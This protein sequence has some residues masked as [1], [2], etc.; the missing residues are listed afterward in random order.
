MRKRFVVAAV[1]IICIAGLVYASRVRTRQRFVPSR[2]QIQQEFGVPVTLAYITRGDIDET[3]EVTGDVAALSSVVLSAK[4]PG[5]VRYVN[6]RAGDP[7]AA[8]QVAVE[9]DRADAES[10]L[11]QAE[12]AV[13]VARSRLSQ[14][15]TALKVQETQASAQIEQAKAQLEAAESQLAVVRNP[16]RSQQEAIAENQVVSAKASLANAESNLKRV[17]NLYDQGAISAQQL[18]MA[19]TQYDV[20]KSQYDSAVQSLSMAREGGRKEEIRAAEQQVRQAREG[21]RTAKANA[22]QVELRREDVRSAEAGLKQAEAGLALARQQLSYC[23]VASPISGF[24]SQR[25]TE[26]G[27]MAGAGVP[28]MT[29]VDLRT[30]YFEAQV[31]ETVL[32][33]VRVGRSVDVRV[34]AFPGRVF[35]GRVVRILP[36]ASSASRNL[37]VRVNVANPG[38]EL[39]PGMFARGSVNIGTVRGALLVPTAA[40]EERYGDKILFTVKQNRAVLHKITVGATNESHTQIVDGAGLA[41]GDRVVL[42]GHAGLNDGTRVTFGRETRSAI[43]K[44]VAQPREAAR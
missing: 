34:D 42:T 9:L 7:L 6:G 36:V 35:Q 17:Q 22:A 25:M 15:R 29:V 12:A 14:A 37:A 41:P 5:Q 21:L 33:K 23:T 2:S 11:R 26:P 16:M 38:G 20:A 40:I 39:R 28:L 1:I 30:V 43:R 32:R 4:I 19:K 44:L 8:G 31:S 10:Q 27:Q 3:V 18:D 24:I 13:N